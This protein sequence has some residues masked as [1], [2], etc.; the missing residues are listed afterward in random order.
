MSARSTSTSA[1]AILRVAASQIPRVLGLVDRDPASPTYGCADRAYWHYRS[2]DFP[3]AR[4]QEA[5]LL[6]SLAYRHDEVDPRLHG[7]G[8]VREWIAAI[9]GF[10]SRARRRSGACDEAYPNEAGFCPT[11]FTTYAV[12]ETALRVPG[13]EVPGLARSADW[14]LRRENP[15]VA[16]QMAAAALALHGVHRLTGDVRYLEGSRRKVE[17]ILDRQSPEGFFPEY[18][19]HDLGYLSITLGLL[20]VLHSRDPDPRLEGALRRA[21]DF[22]VARLDPEGDYD[23]AGTSRRTRFLYPLGLALLGSEAVE[24]VGRGIAAG[25]ILNPA[26]MDDRYV[27]PF[28][29]DYLLAGLELSKRSE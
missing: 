24:R 13:L 16:N 25:S 22:L 20:A 10:W 14:L 19:G 15:D 7:N 29:T 27:I 12:A 18:G 26:W 21:L 4:F 8:R 1:E 11:A 3:N 9:V 17:R 2:T 5:C 23:P 6:L 28:A